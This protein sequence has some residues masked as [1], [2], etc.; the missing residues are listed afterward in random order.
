MVYVILCDRLGPN[1]NIA[2]ADYV[3][4]KAKCEWKMLKEVGRT[5]KGKHVIDMKR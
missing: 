1:M 2:C 5:E 3:K 4:E